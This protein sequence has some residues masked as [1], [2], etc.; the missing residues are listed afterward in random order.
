MNEWSRILDVFSGKVKVKIEKQKPKKR[1]KPKPKVKVK[2]EKQKPKPP[3]IFGPFVPV[4]Y[5]VCSCCKT[6]KSKTEFYKIRTYGPDVTHSNCKVC[7]RAKK[8]IRDQAKRKL[9]NELDSNN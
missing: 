4:D 8:N 6:M 2:T 3:V 5:K 9:K 7:Y 1:G